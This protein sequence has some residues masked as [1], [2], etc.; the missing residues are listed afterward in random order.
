MRTFIL[1]VVAGLALGGCATELEVRPLRAND[2]NRAGVSYV[3][4]FTQY[5]VTQT[6]RVADCTAGQE[7]L[8]LKVEAS[9]GQADDGAHAYLIDP[10]SLQRLLSISEF[11]ATYQDGSNMLRTVNASVEDRTGQFIGNIVQTVASLAPVAMGLPAPGS[12]P[13]PPGTSICRP[14]VIAALSRSTTLKGQLDDAN[15]Q[16]TRANDEVLAAAAIAAQ[17]GTSIDTATRDRL[18]AATRRLHDLRGVQ[19]GLAAQLSDA[20]RPITYQRIVRWP[21]SSACFQSLPHGVDQEA[22]GR[23]FLEGATLPTAPEV[24]LAIERAGSFGRV[25]VSGADCPG[26]APPATP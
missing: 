12:T 15:A 18:G 9:S 5:T 14:E 8:A 13:P 19:S 23:W 2:S 10:A 3:L 25:P 11:N 22:L 24:H 21:E 6:W 26:V 17:M 1:A 20:L 16:V 4:P 7:R